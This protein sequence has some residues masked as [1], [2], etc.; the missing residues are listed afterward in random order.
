MK[1]LILLALLF[2]LTV[3]A[4]SGDEEAVQHMKL[5][6]VTSAQE[7]K[8]VFFDTTAQIKS[9]KTLDVAEL[10][11]IHFITYS[12]E[13]SIAYYAENL[14]GKQQKLAKK[15]A[16]V[17]EDIHINSENNRQEATKKHLK[18]YF[19]LAERFGSAL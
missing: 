13:K 12:L 5:P 9:K 3:F 16:V 17:V 11:E 10:Q 7:A 8:K 18:K 1:S 19:K 6:D 14:S 2:P 4:M 15:M